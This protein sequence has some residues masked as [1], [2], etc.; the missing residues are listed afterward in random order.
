MPTRSTKKHIVEILPGGDQEESSHAKT[1]RV[2]HY[3][4]NIKDVN[5]NPE[6]KYDRQIIISENKA[7]PT[8]V[9]EQ[10]KNNISP[11]NSIEKPE[12]STNTENTA[13]KPK[14]NDVQP[15]AEKHKQINVSEESFPTP[16]AQT[17]TK[18]ILTAED[19]IDK[20]EQEDNTEYLA[21]NPQL[22][23]NTRF[24]PDKET[25]LNVTENVSANPPPKPQ[26]RAE[27]AADKIITESE[28]AEI[29]ENTTDNSEENETLSSDI[30][31]PVKNLPD[32]TLIHGDAPLISEI[33]TNA[34][35]TDRK[36]RK[37]SEQLPLEPTPPVEDRPITQVENNPISKSALRYVKNINNKLKITKSKAENYSYNIR[38]KAKQKISS[39]TTVSK[40]NISRIQE[41]ISSRVNRISIPKNIN[42]RLFMSAAE[43]RPNNNKRFLYALAI[44]FLI[45]AIL[46]YLYPVSFMQGQVTTSPPEYQ[47][48]I[49]RDAEGFTITL[50]KSDRSG[51]ESPIVEIE[52][53]IPTSQHQIVHIVVPG[54]TLWF[55][56][57]R[58]VHD[59][60]QYPELARL[61]NIKNPHLI[62]PGDRVLIIKNH[63]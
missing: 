31:S 5:G 62:Y 16:P 25:Q 29:A 13:D 14:A 2:H 4:V 21:T 15:E 58:Y 60:M 48:K 12:Q 3:H 26:A 40:N 28:H 19:T 38:E 47:A 23:N 10:V 37:D 36:T 35:N 55:I 46:V 43:A 11:A 33:E 17:Q 8:P 56:A 27:L 34:N 24:K 41:S 32:T 30:E 1:R 9:H 49:E 42:K 53:D 59:A 63:P 54:D 39:F 50:E 20:P 44:I 18:N 61:S 45:A 57:K 52:H 6:L 7:S 51:S 22:I